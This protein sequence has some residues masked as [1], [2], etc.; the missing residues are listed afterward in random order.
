MSSVFIN[1]D[2]ASNQK[3]QPY[4]LS[5]SPTHITWDMPERMRTINAGSAITAINKAGKGW[6]KRLIPLTGFNGQF[7]GQNV[8]YH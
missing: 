7:H 5:L 8:L 1:R 2:I 4:V 3:Q 6:G